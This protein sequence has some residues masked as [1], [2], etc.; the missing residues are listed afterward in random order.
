MATVAG[1]IV[2][3]RTMMNPE[4]DEPVAD[5]RADDPRKPAAALVAGP[6]RTAD[7]EFV[8]LTEAVARYGREVGPYK[9]YSTLRAHAAKR[10]RVC[11][12]GEEIA[13]YKLHD[14][15]ALQKADLE[16]AINADVPH[17]TEQRADRTGASQS[18]MTPDPRTRLGAPDKPHWSWSAEGATP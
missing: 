12:G 8:L 1:I 11:L 3:R 17:H 7:E 15:W 5:S 6:I 16:G 13:A 14:R 18:P 2:I 9:A 4:P 10:G